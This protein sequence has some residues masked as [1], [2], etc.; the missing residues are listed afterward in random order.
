VY[1]PLSSKGGYAA[2]ASHLL[3]D[4]SL[5]RFPVPFIIMLLMAGCSQPA[6]YQKE[7][8]AFGT[9]VEVTIYGADRLLADKA[10]E[11]ARQQ[12]EAMTE[13]W[14]A[15]R[16]SAVTRANSLITTGKSF[17][18]EPQLLPLIQRA[19]S[20]SKQSEGLFNP[21]IGKLIALW[22]FH[23]NDYANR[24]PPS[25]SKIKAL[26]E[27]Y[28]CMCD[29]MLTGTRLSSTNRYVQL[30]FG[31]FAKGYGVGQVV[32]RLRKMGIENLII[33]AGGDL[34]AIGN[35]GD[36]PWRIGIRNPRGVGV[37]ASVEINRDESVFTSGDYERYF[38]FK[39]ERYH[40]IIDPRTGYPARG[41]TSATVIDVDSG[42][43]DAAATALVV[44]GPDRWV[45]IARAMRVRDVLLI[46]SQGRA[47]M[48]PSMAERLHFESDHRPSTIVSDMP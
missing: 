6:I 17:E 15:W 5:L 28:P 46:D 37:V 43:A 34:R 23:N 32:D 29:L 21:A 13:V 33:N 25:N 31:A 30:D 27:K 39:G 41:V 8:F 1:K 3:H 26:V 38:V 44:A 40:H 24:R 18:V 45:S 12:F 20:L 9:L 7:F 42:A 14:H 4:V 16:P 35:H 11:T 36:R 22:G 2:S 10:F 48:T 47:H 19:K